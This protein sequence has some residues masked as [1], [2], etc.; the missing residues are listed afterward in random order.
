MQAGANEQRFWELRSRVRELSR[1][2]AAKRSLPSRRLLALLE[3]L[4]SYDVLS[5]AVYRIRKGGRSAVIEDAFTVTSSEVI[6][7]SKSPKPAGFFEWWSK[8][9]ALW[10]AE[11]SVVLM[12]TVLFVLSLSAGMVLGFSEPRYANLLL[13]QSLLEQISDREAWF[14][15]LADTPLQSGLLIAWNNIRVALT[16]FLAA[17]VFGIGGVLLLAFNGLFMGTAAGYC[18]RFGLEQELLDFVAIHGPLEISIL[19]AATAAGV[20]YGRAFL[21]GS[22]RTLG[23]RLTAA[24]PKALTMLSGVLPWLI[25]AAVVETFVSPNQ[26][27]PVGIKLFLSFVLTVLFWLWNTKDGG[28]L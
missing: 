14:R 19:I 26:A 12:L 13:P 7:H 9:R 16:C 11:V 17:S 1:E 8:Y 3:M 24:A 5:S 18:R 4:D 21:R 23:G 25:V 27:V 28:N 6:A 2:V 20:V 10:R 15:R 22:I